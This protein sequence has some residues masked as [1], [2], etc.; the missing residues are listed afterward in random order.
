MTTVRLILLPS[1]GQ[2]AKILSVQGAPKRSP[3]CIA[4]APGVEVMGRE[5]RASGTTPA[6]RKAAAFSQL[7]GD[8]AAPPSE[9]AYA[10][11]AGREESFMLV[12]AR[13]KV[14][15]W[16]S[17]AAETGLAPD[18]I[19][20]DFALLPKPAGDTAHLADRGDAVVRTAQAGFAC[21]PDLLR[22]MTNGLQIVELDFEKTIVNAVRSGA[23]ADAPNLLTGLRAGAR[24]TGK[25]LPVLAACAAGIALTLAAATPWIE[26][27]R[28]DA[29]TRALH[30]EAIEV[31]R[32]VLPDARR[33]V[34]PLTQLREA[35]LPQQKSNALLQQAAG[36]LEGL[37][38]TPGVR[39][40][41][42][43][44]GAD[45]MV[46]ANLST[47]DLVQLQPL[48]DHLS[49]LG[50]RSTETPKDGGVNSQNVDLLLMEAS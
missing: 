13:K 1:N 29:E 43:E 2:K 15:T 44:L 4:V 35:A 27:I 47:P 48:R 21:Q 38:R 16:Q 26:S 34:D 5:I 32:T 45:G 19:I 33:I 23:A 10:V 31:A 36:L 40:S 22:L 12:A 9:T 20:P 37:A 3:R 14:A 24:E 7:S 39:L 18:A 49:S 42:L 6:Q 41:R 11:G 17:A 50:L 30:A 46:H 28:F 25:V 8:L